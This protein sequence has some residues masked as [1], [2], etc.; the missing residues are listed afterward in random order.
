MT[1]EGR[2]RRFTA[3]SSDEVVFLRSD[4][5][6]TLPLFNEGKEED[7]KDE[8]DE[9]FSSAG[10]PRL[11]RFAMES[12]G[13][14]VF[15]TPDEKTKLPQFDDGKEGAS[16]DASLLKNEEFTHPLREFS[17]WLT[18]NFNPFQRRDAQGRWSKG[19]WSLTGWLGDLL[20]IG[21]TAAL[22]NTVKHFTDAEKA[23]VTPYTTNAFKPINEELRSGKPGA[24]AATIAT[25]KSA[26]DRTP[27]LKRPVKTY[28]GVNLQGE[29]KAKFDAEIAHALKTGGKI[30][31]PGFI[32]SSLNSR[33]STD[34]AMRRQDKFGGDLV[35]YQISARK[36]AYVN[37]LSAHGG[38]KEF[39]MNHNSG[40]KVLGTRMTTVKGR[41]VQVVELEQIS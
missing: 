26:L 17:R 4:E 23:A 14:I 34:W 6:T 12:P 25:I 3:E 9:D 29:A 38:E 5:K 40:F 39:L 10:D 33:V 1:D 11:Q 15:L 21:Q 37:K 31:M 20:G 13:E 8:S 7:E 28:R 16:F 19:G 36:G 2:G 41:K 32:S 22:N 30:E 18:E 27:V 24:H 35:M